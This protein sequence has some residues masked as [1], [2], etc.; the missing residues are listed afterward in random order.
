VQQVSY[1]L[2][3]S[4]TALDRITR[5]EWGKTSFLGLMIHWLQPNSDPGAIQ[6]DLGPV[7]G[8]DSP[9]YPRIV[10]TNTSRN[11]AAGISPH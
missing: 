3:S 6:L 7:D 5:S 11:L 8:P 10:E 4:S 9:G 1:L 2:S